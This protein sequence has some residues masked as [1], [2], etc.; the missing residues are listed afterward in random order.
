MIKKMNK[1]E[2]FT[3]IELLIS[4]VIFVF[5][6]GLVSTSYISIV[7]TQKEANEVRK[8]YSELR[9][10]VDMLAEEV[11]LSAVD[12]DCYEGSSSFTDE[13][14]WCADVLQP[15]TEGRSNYLAL[16]RKGGKEKT[17]FKFEDN[18][19]FMT[20]AYKQNGAWGYA[21]GFEAIVGQSNYQQILSDNIDVTNL[22]FYVFPDVNP[23]SS[24]HYRE[25]AKQFQPKL[26]IFMSVKNGLNAESNFE[27]DF[28]TSVSSRVYSRTI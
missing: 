25:N 2:G 12:Y 21:P 10:F 15:L 20:K 6:L 8:I 7:R 16:V 28:Q 26:T 27:F 9:T 14:Y 23:Y 18:K 3:L 22:T 11:R 17:V 5:F 24:E 4:I 13:T 19:V 1:R